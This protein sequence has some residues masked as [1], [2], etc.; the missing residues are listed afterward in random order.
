MPIKAA[1]LIYIYFFLNIAY[2]WK[3]KNIPFVDIIILVSGFVLRLGFG[4]LII[5]VPISIGY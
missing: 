3:L 4:S 5:N 2:S 1:L